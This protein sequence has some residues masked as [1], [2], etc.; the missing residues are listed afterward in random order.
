MEYTHCDSI[1]QIPHNVD[2]LYSTRIQRERISSTNGQY[3]E[4]DYCINA[5]RLSRFSKD[6]LVMH[7]LPCNGELA[8]E[9]DDDPRAVY[10]KQA[11][12]GVPV[13]QAVL[14][15]LLEK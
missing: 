11:H 1:E 8:P 9:V 10:F 6:T 4:A 3:Q 13:R 12:N 7:P 15:T 5:K 14:L 2:A